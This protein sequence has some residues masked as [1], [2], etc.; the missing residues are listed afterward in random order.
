M[1]RLTL[2]MI[3]KNEEKYLREC[4]ES[5]K[6]LA[7]EIVI[8]DTGS[9]DNTLAIAQEFG[10]NVFSFEWVNDFA[11]ARNYALSKSTG[12]WILYLD[13]DERLDS[14]SINEVRNILEKKTKFGFYCTVQNIDTDESRDNSFRY[15]RYFINSKGIEFTGKVHE[16]IEE[17]LVKNE[18]QLLNSNIIINHIGY[19]V[20][21]EEKQKKA[22]RNL[23]LLLEEYKNNNSGYYAFQ[24][25]NTYKVLKDFENA[26]K[27]YLTAS[28]DKYLD[29]SYVVECFSSI[30]FI[31]LINHNVYGA[32]NFIIK[33]LQFKTK[34]A[35]AH[36]L[37]SKIYFRKK[38]FQK[39]ELHCKQA[40]ELNKKINPYEKGITIKLDLEEIIFFGMM[41]A[42]QNNNINSFKAYQSE[43][44]LCYQNKKVGDAKERIEVIRKLVSAIKLSSSEIEILIKMVNDYNINFIIMLLQNETDN[45]LKQK[46][47]EILTKIFDNN[48][49]IK[50]ALVKT[51]EV[52]NEPIKAVKLLES[53]KMEQNPAA[54][55]YLISLY[56][57]M[58][59]INK[60]NLTIEKIERNFSGIPEVAE[61]IKFLKSKL[62]AYTNPI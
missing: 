6:E 52:A 53:E 9:T 60:V 42:L 29:T 15:I 3:V 50:L 18:Y 49:E 19:N 12:D 62:S 24:L 23:D 55:F 30:A 48:M 10:A 2:S 43:L 41:V 61:R 32:E 17:S 36:M 45:Q 35:Y 4:L 26:K 44:F 22:K 58:K 28:I 5:V 46:I 27:Y 38:D 25:G 39:A 31:E 34:N 14:K 13:A 33:G 54:L 20:S 56:L 40:F 21:K 51:Y 57:K 11:A 59:D 8:V 16:Q 7:D 37:A 47:F 1:P